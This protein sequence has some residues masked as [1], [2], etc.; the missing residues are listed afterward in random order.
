M[1]V[2]ITGDANC[3]YKFQL[4]PVLAGNIALH[5]FLEEKRQLYDIETLW[6][7]GPAFDEKTQ[8]HDIAKDYAMENFFFDAN[9]FHPKSADPK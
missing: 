1:H 3:N 8:E 6:T 5:L 4:Y 2:A 7:V 9:Q